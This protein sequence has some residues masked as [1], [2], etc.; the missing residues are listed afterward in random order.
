MRSSPVNRKRYGSEPVAGL[1]RILQGVFGVGDAND[2]LSSPG[3]VV[4]R[5]GLYNYHEGDLFTPGTGNWVF[6]PPFETP[7]NTIW[8]HAFLR[9]PNMFSPV[10]PPQIMSN[11]NI[12]VNGIGGQIAGQIIFQPL[13]DPAHAPEQGA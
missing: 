4:R 9:T 1:D 13:L 7:L 2:Q 8:G 5:P 3:Y 10:Q 6:E 11:P 12:T